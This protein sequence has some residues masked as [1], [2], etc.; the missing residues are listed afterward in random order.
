M[1]HESDEK[2]CATC[3]HWHE[4]PQAPGPL[5]LSRPRLGQCRC[6]PP[7]VTG[8]QINPRTGEPTGAVQIHYIRL[9]ADY[10]ACGQHERR[11]A[12]PP[13]N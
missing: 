6:G 9:P 1:S 10:P 11:Q 2:R 5:D 7:V 4:L 8:F 3:R 13:A 12:L